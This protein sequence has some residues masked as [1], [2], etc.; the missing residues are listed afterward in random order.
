MDNKNNTFIKED[1]NFTGTHMKWKIKNVLCY[2]THVHGPYDDI[3]C[4]KH[5]AMS[6]K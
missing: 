6:Q 3:F 5:I 2:K 1:T 4:E